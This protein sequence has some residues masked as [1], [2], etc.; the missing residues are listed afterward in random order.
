MNRRQLLRNTI[1]GAVGASA[2]ATTGPPA[3]AREFPENFDASKDLANA[4]WKPAFLSE[5]QNETLLLLSDIIIPETDT[6]GAKSALVN[7]FIDLLLAAETHDTQQSFLN[8]LAY[9]DGA[10]RSRHGSAFVHLPKEAQ[11]ELL[12]FFAYPNSLQTWGE[13]KTG[14]QTG[15]THFTNLK[16]WISRIFYSSEAGMK[17]LGWN[18]ESPHGEWTGCE[19]EAKKRG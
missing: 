5:H 15:Y 11:L 3:E 1:L 9:I 2:V 12:H 14:E 18:G 10:A 7:R 6:P 19:P 17:A 13:G 16:G 4:N 8:S